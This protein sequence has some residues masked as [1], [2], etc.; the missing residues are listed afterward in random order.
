M[1]IPAGENAEKPSIQVI[2]ADYAL[3]YALI[4]HGQVM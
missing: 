1:D 4:F 2:S 3:F